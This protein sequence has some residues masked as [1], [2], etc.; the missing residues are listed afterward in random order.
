MDALIRP[1]TIP[2]RFTTACAAAIW[3]WPLGP[4]IA[5]CRPQGPPLTDEMLQTFLDKPSRL[6]VMDATSP[7]DAAEMAIV[8]SQY[9]AAKPMALPALVSTIPQAS[10]EQRRAIG[11]GLYRTVSA[12]LPVDQG[13]SARTRDAVRALGDADVRR[14][15]LR[16]ETDATT[17]ASTLADAASD[18]TPAPSPQSLI[19]APL[20]DDPITSLKLSDAFSLPSLR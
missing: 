2:A 18:P 13:V 9:V 8:V 4:A 1:R 14:A 6:L 19:T 20:M 3:M 5:A 11:A 7:D 15:Y 12:C 17:P 10:L 16:A